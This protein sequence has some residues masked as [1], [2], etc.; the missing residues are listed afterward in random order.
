MWSLPSSMPRGDVAMHQVDDTDPYKVA[1]LHHYTY[2]DA[3][4]R[5]NF[6]NTYVD[7]Q[8]RW[9]SPQGGVFNGG[10]SGALF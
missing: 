1:P 6:G 2:D 10:T 8:L 3:G 5:L 7:G 4:N 9:Q